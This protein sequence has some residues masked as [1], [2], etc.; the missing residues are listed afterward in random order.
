MFERHWLRKP[1]PLRPPPRRRPGGQLDSEA[2]FLPTSSTWWQPLHSSRTHRRQEFAQP[3]LRLPP[4]Q[5]ASQPHLRRAR[6]LHQ[7]QP[8]TPLRRLQH[9]HLSPSLGA[10][11][12]PPP[13]SL[14]AV[15]LLAP[16]AGCLIAG[17]GAEHGSA[18]R[19][20]APAPPPSRC[21]PRNRPVRHHKR[22]YP[23]LCDT[24]PSDPPAP[25]DCSSHMHT[26]STTADPADPLPD[27]LGPDSRPT[28][29]LLYRALK[30]SMPVSLSVA[31]L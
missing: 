20:E 12:P 8:S 15:E 29:D 23:L 31:R 10:L 7:R 18:S 6:S 4:R 5:I 13:P 28:A 16:A 26:H 9:K 3:C 17:L 24:T 1:Q 19:L 22:R 25:A 14:L 21:R 30:S 27:S 11:P 2:E